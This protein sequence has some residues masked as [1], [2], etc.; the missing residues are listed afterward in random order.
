VFDTGRVIPAGAVCQNLVMR[1]RRL[2]AVLIAISLASAVALGVFDAVLSPDPL[3][4]P[5]AVA[6][7]VAILVAGAVAGG[8]KAVQLAAGRGRAVADVWTLAWL[9]M[10]AAWVALPWLQLAF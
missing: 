9:G 7:A 4:L 6:L 8:W 5:D 2:A 10:F 1:L 3:G